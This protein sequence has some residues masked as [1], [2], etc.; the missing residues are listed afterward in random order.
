MG[1]PQF[2]FT[3]DYPTS[4][5]K[6]VDHSDHYSRCSES[7]SSSKTAHLK[8]VPRFGYYVDPTQSD[9]DSSQDFWYLKWN[10][11]RGPMNQ[12]QKILEYCQSIEVCSNEDLIRSSSSGYQ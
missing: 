1:F 4:L 8:A 11:T 3:Q 12:A 10:W 7:S 2:R 9:F 5:I 6:E